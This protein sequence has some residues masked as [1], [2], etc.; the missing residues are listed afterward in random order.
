MLGEMGAVQVNKYNLCCVLHSPH[1]V[2]HLY[3]KNN[4]GTIKD[5]KPCSR[6]EICPFRDSNPTPLNRQSIAFETLYHMLTQSEN[7][8]NYESQ[9]WLGPLML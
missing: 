2:S 3:N 1:A 5:K 6:A 8:L 7:R 9:E 4:A